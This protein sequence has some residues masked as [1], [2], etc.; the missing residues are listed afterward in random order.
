MKKQNKISVAVLACLMLLA[1]AMPF[2]TATIVTKD[3][4]A[5][6]DG[7][8]ICYHASLLTV[9]FTSYTSSGF[10]YNTVTELR[11]AYDLNP[12]Y[13]ARYNGAGQ[14]VAIVDAYGSPTIYS[15]LLSFIQW[16]NEYA[17]ANLPWTSLFAVESHLHIYYPL[18]KPWFNYTSSDE[19]GWSLEVTLDVDMV[20]AIAPGANIALVIAPNDNFG[21]LLSAVDYAVDNHLGCVISQSW[22]APE[23]EL[24]G[25]SGAAVMMQGNSIYMSAA[26]ARITVF[27]SAGDEGAASYYG[28]YDNPLFPSSDPYVTAVGG[29][30]L[31]MHCPDGYS[32]GTGNWTEQTS[33]GLTYY[34]EIAGNDYEA[35]VADGYPSPFDDVTTGGAMS[36]FFTLPYW[37]RGITLTYTNG[38]TIPATMRCTSD[39]SFD[40]GVYGGLGAVA[41]TT[42]PIYAGYY[43]VGGTSAGSPFWSALTAIACQ[44]AGTNLGYINPSLYDFYFDGTAY[45]SGAFHDITIGDNTYPTGYSVPGYNATRG[46]DPPTGIGSPDATNLV[47]LMKGW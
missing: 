18:G 5:W 29:T 1:L 23:W 42:S 27:A 37:Q 17:G 4:A 34:Y 21:P 6:Y 14:T 35:M 32:E 12:L 33:P 30:N 8:P 19:L 43:I 38:T 28:P 11:R 47:P 3:L 26:H 31:F 9:N 44:Y 2:A 13:T 16:Q 15:D 41:W 25:P 45:S 24:T 40:S 7:G 22:G 36:S 20:H 10:L 39:V 46:W